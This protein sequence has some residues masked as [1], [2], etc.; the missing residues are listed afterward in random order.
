[1]LIEHL[2]DTLI[3]TN[4]FINDLADTASKNYNKFSVPKK[5]GGTRVVY[6]PNKELKL[7]QRVI[8]DDFLK[9]LPVHPACSAY[10]DG[11]SVKENAERHKNNKYLLRIDFVDFF[12]SIT[13]NDILSFL[14]ENKIHPQWNDNDTELL[15]KLVCYN[16]RL[17]MGSVTSPMISNLVCNKLDKAIESICNIQDIIYSRYADDIYLSTNTPN[18]LG[19]MPK[20]I[21]NILRKID[22]PKHLIINTSKTQHSSK[23]TRMT[24][25]GLK[26]TNMGT[27]SIGREKKREIRSLVHKWDTLPIEKK[28]YLQ[29]YLSYCVSVEPL[30]INALCEKFSAKIIKKIQSYKF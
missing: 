28:K 7:L 12:K 1:M 14:I 18:I 13:H 20:K 4:D 6:Q 5:N 3:L 2:S 29:G 9:I 16:G 26:I 19:M 24:I 27:I 8:H 11:A 21:T 25:T 30:F 17:T 22:Y 15:L 10:L 23:K